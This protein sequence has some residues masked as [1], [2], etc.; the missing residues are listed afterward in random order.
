MYFVTLN[1]SICFT[2]QDSCTVIACCCVLGACKRNISDYNAYSSNKNIVYRY[3]ATTIGHLSGR[4]HLELTV[5]PINDSHI[6]YIWG[7]ISP[8]ASWYIYVKLW[9]VHAPGIPGTFS[10]PPPVSDPDIHHGT[11]VTHVPWCMPDSL[12]SGFLWGRRRGKRSR[13]SRRMRNPQFYVSGNRPITT[14]LRCQ[15]LD[16]SL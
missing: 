16:L 11:C 9:V 13:H 6:E 10:P 5:K 4:E 2:P 3:A 12:S 8:W 7:E 1:S 14:E 15:R